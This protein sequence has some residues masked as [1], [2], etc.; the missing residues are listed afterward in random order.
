MSKVFVS[1][2]DSEGIFLISFTENKDKDLVSLDYEENELNAIISLVDQALVK[3]GV[4]D[5]E[6]ERHFILV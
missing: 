6:N 4:I 3:A 1:E 5:E 2:G